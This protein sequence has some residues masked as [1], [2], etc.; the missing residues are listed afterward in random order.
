LLAPRQI[1]L[2][3]LPRPWANSIREAFHQQEEPVIDAPVRVTVQ[4]L[5]DGSLVIHNYNEDATIV[6]VTFP[7]DGKYINDFTGEQVTANGK[8]VKLEMKPRSNIWLKT[9]Q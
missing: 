1:G 6:S 5:S 4:R 3:E 2:V 7:K 8:E 9:R